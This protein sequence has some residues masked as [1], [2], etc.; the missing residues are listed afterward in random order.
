[1]AGRSAH[2]ARARSSVAHRA[3]AEQ[4]PDRRAAGD[5]RPHGGG[6]RRAH[7]RQAGLHVPHTDWRLGLRTGLGRLQLRLIALIRSAL[8]PEDGGSASLL[9]RSSTYWPDWSSYQSS[10]QWQPCRWPDMPSAPTVEAVLQRR[11]QTMNQTSGVLGA[12]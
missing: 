7:S 4:P 10:E 2:A 1:G 9:A 8:G 3:R 11:E 5:H 12:T 6:A